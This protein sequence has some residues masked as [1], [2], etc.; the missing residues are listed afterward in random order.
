MTV[1]KYLNY[2]NKN[3]RLFGGITKLSITIEPFTINTNSGFKSPRALRE[4]GANNPITYWGVFLDN[5]N[6][7][8]T[9]KKELAEQTK[10][11]MEKWLKTT[12]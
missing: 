8:Y 7:S 11:W 9:S 5:E 3:R 2:V 4:K 10:E 12:H 1:V 6:I